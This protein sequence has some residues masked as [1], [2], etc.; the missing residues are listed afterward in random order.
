MRVLVLFTS[1]MLDSRGTPSRC[2]NLTR[3]L[4]D[5]P[6]NEVLV[7]SGDPPGSVPEALGIPHRCVAGEPTAARL[8]EAVAHFRPDVVYG[9]TEKAA[10]ALAQLSPGPARIVDLHGDLAAE[11]LEQRWRPLGRRLRA[12]LRHRLEEIRWLG[13][14]DG[15]TVVSEPLARRVRRLGRPTEVIW[16]GVDPELF[17]APPKAP[18]RQITVAYAGNFRPYQG[19]TVLVAAMD[20]LDG[21]FQLM[22]VG[23]PTGAEQLLESARGRLGERLSVLDP[24]PYEEIPGLLARA[25]VLTV[26]RPDCRSARFGF[27][28]KLP[29]YLALGRAVV[30]TDV[31]DQP[32]VVRDGENGLVV[33][34]GNAAA[35]AAALESLGDPERRR[36]LAAA[37]RREAETRL[38]WTSIGQALHRF[39]EE[40]CA[41]RAAAESGR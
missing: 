39:L 38:S 17:N 12:F 32:R 15:Y 28:S 25:D 29:E 3:A 20:R 19:L 18:S 40:R 23:D 36:R 5:Q 1:R 9:Q 11:K 10:A 13:G 37:A 24:V 6:G 34:A 14:M 30:V 21:R 41:A 16:G 26:P 8:A 7:L 4:H 35:L 27:P 2:R 33:P 22:L 31:G